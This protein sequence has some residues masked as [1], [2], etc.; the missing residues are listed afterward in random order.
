MSPIVFMIATH[1]KE[2]DI[3][4]LK[5]LESQQANYQV[6]VI[7]FK[8]LYNDQDLMTYIVGKNG[9]SVY[10]YSPYDTVHVYW[11]GIFFWSAI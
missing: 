11:W 1:N 7:H 3:L 6:G 2:S 9:Y 5:E 10:K 8:Q 4:T